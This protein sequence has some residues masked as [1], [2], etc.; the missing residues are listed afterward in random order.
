MTSD[1]TAKEIALLKR[2]SLGEL[3]N[4]GG[5]PEELNQLI[6]KGYVM[7]GLVSAVPVNLP[8]SDFRLSVFGAKQLDLAC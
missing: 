6:A 8:R 2:V 7:Q 4:V 1:L 3:R 5:M